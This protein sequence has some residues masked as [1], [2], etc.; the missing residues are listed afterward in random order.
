LRN[1]LRN[2]RQAGAT[3]A[4][5]EL[6]IESSARSV[7]LRV[8]D[9]GP[10]LAPEQL[11]KLFQPFT[12]SSKPGSTGLGLY[13]CRRYVELMHGEIRVE[14]TPGQGACFTVRLPG[15]VVVSEPAPAPVPALGSTA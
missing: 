13:L 4:R 5:I 9:D 7:L 11:G 8:R 1:L 10:G 6:S 15:R 2:A 12:S 14:S 3:R